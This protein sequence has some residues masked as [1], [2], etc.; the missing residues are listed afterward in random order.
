MVGPLVLLEVVVEL[1]GVIEETEVVELIVDDFD[2]VVD[3]VEVTELDVVVDTPDV[4]DVFEVVEVTEL[5]VVAIPFLYMLRR[6]GPPQYSV[7]LALQTKLHWVIAGSFPATRA[8]P[9]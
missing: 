6:F 3:A 4:D 2:V 1:V 7:L 8:D 5:E 9:A